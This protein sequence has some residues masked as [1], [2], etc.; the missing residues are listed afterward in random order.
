MENSD[1]WDVL[2]E[3]NRDFARVVN[4]AMDDYLKRKLE[5]KRDRR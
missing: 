2:P 4:G 5:I 1:V 3:D